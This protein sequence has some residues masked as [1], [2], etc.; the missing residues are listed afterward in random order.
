MKS[1]A[2]R[3]TAG[4]IQRELGVS[5][6]Y[7]V[8][9]TLWPLGLELNDLR[10]PDKRG[11]EPAFAAERISVQPR[12]FALL[13]G[14]VQ[15]G[16]V[17]VDRPRIRLRVKD[18]EVTNVAYKLPKSSGGAS[19]ESPFTSLSISD[20]VIDA[21]IEGN[22][23]STTA[24][25]VDVYA[26]PG[27]SFEVAVRAAES[28]IDRTRATFDEPSA[29]AVDEDVICQLDLRARYSGST[30]LVR[31]LSLLGVADLSDK[32]GTR[33]TCSI[34]RLRDPKRQ[35]ALRA[36]QFRADFANGDS[37][38]PK[39]DGNVVLRA[40]VAL[41]NRFVKAPP[42]KGWIGAS[43]DVSYDGRNTLPDVRGKLRGGK[44]KLEG[45]R[46]AKYLDATV[47]IDRDVVRVPVFKAGWA[48]A[49]V[50]FKDIVVKQ[51]AD[52]PSISAREAVVERMTFPGLMRDLR[53]YA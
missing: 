40:P 14:R 5:A 48:D 30:L 24:M 45:Y 44:L 29:T 12:V 13:G 49:D 8:E 42:L 33:P 32:A 47:S 51:F 16:D 15:V 35:V 52:K 9:V 10:V 53:R 43:V 2:E 27:P 18:G 23:I 41:T 20:A 3:E 28:H 22:L 26:E 6:T 7:T 38:I 31:R 25:D 21:D 4:L 37:A 46:I 11:G 36:S 1:W 39:L 17:E 34:E 50:T 19:D